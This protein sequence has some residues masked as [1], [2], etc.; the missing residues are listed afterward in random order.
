MHQSHAIFKAD[1]ANHMPYWMDRP[2]QG[3]LKPENRTAS[4]VGASAPNGIPER[5]QAQSWQV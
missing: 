2:K 5:F 1:N 3:N 4:E